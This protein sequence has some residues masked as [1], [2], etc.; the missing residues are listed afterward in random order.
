MNKINVNNIIYNYDYFGQGEQTVVF[1]SGYTCDIHL[2]EPVAKMLSKSY[3]VLVFDNQGIGDTRDNGERLTIES[4][5]ESI[6]KFMHKL[7]IKKPILLGYAMGSTLAL[8]IAKEAPDAIT[9]LILLS[10]VLSWSNRAI[11][12][13]DMLIELRKKGNQDAYFELLYKTA[14][15]SAYKANTPLEVFKEIMKSIPETQT[16]QDQERQAIALKSFNCRKWI[17]DI[18]TPIVILSPKEDQFATPEDVNE[19]KQYAHDIQ[20]EFIDCG[21]AAIMEKP[22][23]IIDLCVKHVVN[24]NKLRQ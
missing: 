24:A 4:M 23:D 6:S 17:G 12:Y 14:F 10:P 5:A 8:Q 7:E 22:N 9:K 11:N 20:I 3:R 15:G 2:W 18:T 13:V 21:H 19:F 1:I 16:I